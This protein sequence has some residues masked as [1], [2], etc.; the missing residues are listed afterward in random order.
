MS[1][2]WSDQALYAAL[3]QQGSDV[4]RAAFEQ[5]Y[6][7]LFAIAHFMVQSAAVAEPRAV[8][9]DCAQEALVKVWK[10]LDTCERIE[11]FRNWARKIV[12]NQTLN[13]LARLRRQPE[14]SLERE[15]HEALVDPENSPANAVA[16]TERYSA[17][18]DLLATA[19][20]SDRSRFVILAK[21]LMGM[22]EEEIA[23]ALSQREGASLKPSH[24][25]V[26]RAKNFRKIYE[27][28]TLKAQFGDL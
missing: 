8:A 17:I 24:V 10:N 4:Q 11:T 19:P 23:Q 7:E 27:N 14:A 26:T 21:Y 20:I 1:Q 28:P 6:R 9:Q 2:Q 12:R 5:L 13:E 15:A 22:T 16:A 25:Q 3:Q 18:L